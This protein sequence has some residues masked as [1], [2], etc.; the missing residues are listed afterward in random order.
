MR[1]LS[2]KERWHRWGETDILV[3]RDIMSAFL[4]CYVTDNGH[5]RSRLLKEWATVEALLSDSGLCRH[6]LRND[7][8]TLRE[9]PRLTSPEAEKP[10]ERRRSLSRTLCAGSD[11]RSSAA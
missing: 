5:D 8:G 6:E 4:A 10:K 11:V 9:V 1:S 7:Q 2:L 3:Q